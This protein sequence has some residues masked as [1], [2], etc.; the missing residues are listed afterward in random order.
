[1]TTLRDLIRDDIYAF[2]KEYENCTYDEVNEDKDVLLDEI[3][4]TI[5][6]HI[7]KYVD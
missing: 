4:D 7:A 2:F 3:M 1:M 5:H 6:E